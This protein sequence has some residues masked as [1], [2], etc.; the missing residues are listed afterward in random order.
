MIFFLN[1]L[2][3]VPFQIDN[4]NLSGA[5]HLGKQADRVSHSLQSNAMEIDEQNT[6]GD[7]TMKSVSTSIFFLLQN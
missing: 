1:V 7:V 3:R 4:D 6:T 2:F 5:D